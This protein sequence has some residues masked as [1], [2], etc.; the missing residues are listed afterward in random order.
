[1]F[2]QAASCHQTLSRWPLIHLT[3][4]ATGARLLRASLVALAIVLSSVMCSSQA[5]VVD[6]MESVQA[7]KVCVFRV[8]SEFFVY[9]GNYGRSD[10]RAD[11]QKAMTVC[12][13]HVAKMQQ[14]LERSGLVAA[15]DDLRHRYDMALSTL[16]S[17][18]TAVAKKGLAENAVS[19]EMVSNMQAV[20]DSLEKA[21]NA[22]LAKAAYKPANE[23]ST[24]YNL[25]VLMQYMDARYMEKGYSI[26]GAAE[27]GSVM[28]GK[29]LDDLVREFDSSFA[30]LLKSQRNSASTL[31]AL[32]KIKTKWL[33]IRGPLINF[34]SKAVPFIVH[35]N[36]LEIVD[37]LN[38]VASE[39]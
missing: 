1:M 8:M 28:A 16:N 17:N 22:L 23:R 18:V 3:G 13:G 21:R 15:A 33:F 37:L 35:K 25:A 30:V 5:A 6:E 10:T 20:V 36:S 14:T 2:F 32:R 27:I 19:A 29:G 34:N 26:Y 31:D 12:S 11:L 9:Q 7:A 38:Q 4:G 39:Y 24:A